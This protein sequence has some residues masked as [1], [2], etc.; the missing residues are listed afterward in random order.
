LRAR[1]PRNLL[2]PRSSSS[3]RPSRSNFTA[4]L[5]GLEAIVHEAM[6]QWDG[7]MFGALRVAAANATVP[8]DLS[9]ALIFYTSGEAVR[10]VEPAFVPMVDALDIWPLKLSGS[11]LPATRLKPLLEEIW[12]P[13]LEGRGTRDAAL[14]VLVPRAAAVSQP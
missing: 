14:A 2:R 6:H 1:R 9:H 5:Y 11:S 13:W 7:E 4:G 12:K 8:R 3:T 10:H